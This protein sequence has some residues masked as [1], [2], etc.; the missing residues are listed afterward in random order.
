MLFI[1]SGCRT[2]KSMTQWRAA[3]KRRKKSEV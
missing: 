1:V 2:T 3:A